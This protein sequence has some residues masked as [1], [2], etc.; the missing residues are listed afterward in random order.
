MKYIR[1]KFYLVIAASLLIVACTEIGPPINLTPDTPTPVGAKKSGLIKDTSYVETS[2]PTADAK[3]VLIE[4]FS[5]QS[6]TNCPNGHQAI[7][8]IKSTNNKVSAATIHFIDNSFSQSLPIAPFD[9]RTALGTT[10][11]SSLD[12]IT[13][14]PAARFDRAS[15]GGAYTFSTPASWVT[16]VNQE[17]AKTSYVN[18]ELASIWDATIHQDSV[19]VKIH[20]TGNAS[21]DTLGVSIFIT[22]DSIV[23]PQ[24]LPTGSTD[25]NYVHNNI[26]RTLLTASSGIEIKGNKTV[27]NVKLY[28][29]RSEV[30]DITKWNI[31]KL[32]IIA[33]VHK[34]N[35]GNKE[36]IQVVEKK[37][38]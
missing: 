9:F 11:S 17:T 14:I 12:G 38:K 36:V 2:I 31:D 34:Q 20:F 19:A 10:I 26:F 30:I 24:I 37:L 16:Y 22:E 7:E 3:R 27:G 5:G 6:C 29:L 18:I 13:G 15:F 28:Q 33:F 32:K 1:S 8:Q 21:A 23:A 25:L 4:E 35:S